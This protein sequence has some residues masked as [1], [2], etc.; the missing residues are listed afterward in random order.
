MSAASTPHP[1]IPR[2]AAGEYAAFY[3][4]Y[5]AAVATDDLIPL[6]ELQSRTVRRT[7]GDLDDS[8]A[9]HRYAE[10]KW[11]IK[12]IVGHLCDG[13]RVFAYR[14]LRVGRGDATPLPGFDENH[15]VAAA[16]FD[17]RPVA[18]LIDEFVHLRQ[19]TLELLAGIEGEAWSHMGSANGH[20][21]STRALAWIIAGHT[22]HHLKVLADRYGVS[23]KS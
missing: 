16:G 15:Y 17:A 9:L 19:S 13:E 20:P 18:R 1:P 2:P 23:L 11:S 14:L 21:I 6:L 5:L 10:G 7:L 3:A 4:P 22:A 8:R 12:E